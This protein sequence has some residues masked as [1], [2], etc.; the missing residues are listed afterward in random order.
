MFDFDHVKL[1]RCEEKLKRLQNSEIQIFTKLKKT[2]NHEKTQNLVFDK[3]KIVKK[4]KNSK[5]PRAQTWK[6]Q[7]PLTLWSS[8]LFI[9]FPPY[10]L[11][12]SPS[13]DP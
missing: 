9:D 13:L 2:S 10:L 11:I 6:K 8:T 7:T 3:T 5:A 1:S 12:L 4:L